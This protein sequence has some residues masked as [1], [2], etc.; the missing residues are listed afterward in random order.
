M[1]SR[2]K[3]PYVMCVESMEVSETAEGH[4]INFTKKTVGSLQNVKTDL[5]DSVAHVVR[6]LFYSKP[7][8]VP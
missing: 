3:E 4:D 5:R 7:N 2:E 1:A 8:L 6:Y